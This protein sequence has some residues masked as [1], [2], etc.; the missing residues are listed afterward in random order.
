MRTEIEFLQDCMNWM[1]ENGIQD[2]LYGTF[3]ARIKEIKQDASGRKE[4]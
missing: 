4:E 3:E 2:Q 1:D